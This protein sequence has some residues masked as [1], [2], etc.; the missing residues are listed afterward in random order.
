M[1]NTTIIAACALLGAACN[2]LNDIGSTP[3]DAAA[4][5]LAFNLLGQQSV[6][7]EDVGDV[8]AGS[9]LSATLSP[10]APPVAVAN[11]T[12]D[13]IV[14]TLLTNAFSKYG[15]FL[16]SAGDLDAL[17]AK[18]V[19]S[20]DATAKDRLAK[21]VNDSWGSM[22]VSINNH[23][24][25]ITGCNAFVDAF[26]GL[27]NLPG[28]SAQLSEVS[29]TAQPE[30]DRIRAHIVLEDVSIAPTIWLDW[31][32]SLCSGSFV[33]FAW[34]DGHS[35]VPVNLK[36]LALDVDLVLT[37]GGE[38][39]E[40]GCCEPLVTATLEVGN[41]VVGP[42][43][44]TLPTYNGD[45]GWTLNF[46]DHISDGM[47]QDLLQKALAE[48]SFSTSTP[49][50]FGP[51]RI[52]EVELDDDGASFT[53]EFDGDGDGLFDACDVCTDSA[54]NF[55]LD[56]D[57]VCSDN[58]PLVANATQSDGDGDGYGD[59]CDSCFG[60]DGDHDPPCY[61]TYCFGDGVDDACDNCVGVNNP[62]QKDTDGDGEGDA[63][64]DDDDGDGILDSNDNCPL[65][66][67]NILSDGDNDGV[68]DVCDN[69]KNTPNPGQGDSDG[70]GLG[71]ACDPDLDGDGV[72]NGA[73]NCEWTPNSA[74]KDGDGDGVGD[75]CDPDPDCNPNDPQYAASGQC[76]DVPLL[77]ELFFD[78]LPLLPGCL[79]TGCVELDP[80]AL[81]T[82]WQ[83]LDAR[84]TPV[85]YRVQTLLMLGA[86]APHDEVTVRA[87]TVFARDRDSR[88]R[89]AATKA[90][91]WARF[92]GVKRMLD[93]TYSDAATNQRQALRSM[94]R[95]SQSAIDDA[96]MLRQSV[97]QVPNHGP[98]YGYTP[99]SR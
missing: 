43:S 25:E 16:Q 65:Y 59:A 93:L 30:D 88:V 69:C 53:H 32:V 37:N 72:L 56:S 52:T 92:G 90:Q 39:L 80:A 5:G 19:S 54:S 8:L 2:D 78:G 94:P 60:N 14:D 71:N 48:V 47:V 83:V 73:D 1:R 28:F 45:L 61:G 95:L 22:Q 57:G 26:V 97:G 42:V 21:A 10:S 50:T 99:R 33:H 6:L 12:L 24:V 36:S 13:D 29:F 27:T 20:V 4:A 49:M 31:G 40:A 75:A 38:C 76:D 62:D 84:T 96:K 17:K 34:G 98:S 68:G 70:D 87:L 89:D 63:C 15:L 44:K 51:M 86:Y 58:C 85:P 55:D 82:M 77:E 35:V 66:A 23:E 46:N 7:Q 11:T 67:S 81:R 9:P 74:Q 41:F 3:N 18:I 64:D 79:G 91:T